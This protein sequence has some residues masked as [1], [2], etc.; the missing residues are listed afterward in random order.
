MTHVENIPHILA[1]GI[2][3]QRSTNSNENYVPIGAGGL[4]SKRESV[5][6][7]NGN[8]LGD[9]I[10]FYFG[11]RM[12]MLYVIK[13]GDQSVL[14]NLKQTQSQ[15]VIYCITSVEQMQVHRLEFVFSN[16]HAVSDLTEF[17][18]RSDVEEILNII[19]I[20]AV[21]ARYW[22]DDN[23][24]D[25]KRRKEAEFLVL[26]DVPVSA[27]LGFAVY[28]DSAEQRLLNLGIDKDK[29]TVKPGFYF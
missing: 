4:I 7:P 20:E 1:N 2:T 10:P 27:I 23:D 12:P 25:L 18:D 11:P 14:Y 8:A 13:L 24:L 6:L 5:L 28:N 9:Y 29:I 22:R 19:D 16:G 15:D 17:F 3:H 21:N 26:G